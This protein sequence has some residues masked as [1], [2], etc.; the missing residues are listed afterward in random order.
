MATV[1]PRQA[2]A[3]VPESAVLTTAASFSAT[4]SVPLNLDL[5]LHF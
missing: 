3:D 5:F 2:G 1:R 4:M